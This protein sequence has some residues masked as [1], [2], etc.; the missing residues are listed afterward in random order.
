M[1]KVD[2]EPSKPAPKAYQRP[3]TGW[4]KVRDFLK[5]SVGVITL[6]GILGIIIILLAWFIIPSLVNSEPTTR[7]TTIT[8]PTTE[9][10]RLEYGADGRTLLVAS[11]GGS[12]LLEYR[13]TYGKEKEF[14][15]IFTQSQFSSVEELNH[16]IENDAAALVS[17]PEQSDFLPDNLRM[18]AVEPLDVNDASPTT[19]EKCERFLRRVNKLVPPHNELTDLQQLNPGLRCHGLRAGD[20][21]VVMAK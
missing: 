9:S 21:L 1:F 17:R 8:P 10:V 2:G 11:R 3:G 13:I 18:M 14:R 15:D 16:K 5:T 20:R 6:I 19:P 7:E 12:K 4:L